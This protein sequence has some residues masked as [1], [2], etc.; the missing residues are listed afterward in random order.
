MARRKTDRARRHDTRAA[1]H[2]AL[3]RPTNRQRR[4][5]ASAAPSSKPPSNA[6]AT[7]SCKSPN[8]KRGPIGSSSADD[9][10]TSVSR[11]SHA[12]PPRPPR[13]LATSANSDLRNQSQPDSPSAPKAVF[14][15]AEVAAA[16]A[17]GWQTVALGQRI[18]RV[19]TAAI[20]LAAAS[21]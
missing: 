11:D 21:H 4:S 12:P 15:D 1:D 18:L 2:R 19:E 16:I 20:A 6:A 17:A 5:N 10:A 13:R 8:R 9:R 3:R 7:A 14:T